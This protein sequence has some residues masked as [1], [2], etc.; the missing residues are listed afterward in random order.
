M[1]LKIVLKCTYVENATGH[2]GRNWVTICSHHENELP[3]IRQFEQGSFNLKLRDPQSYEPPKE[4][5][6]KAEAR[7]RG[8]HDGNHISQL[9]KVVELNGK[10]VEARFYRGGHPNN[11]IELLSKV[12]LKELL[13]IRHGAEVI[14]VVVENEEMVQLALRP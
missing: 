14:V 6:Y 8:Q 11:T 12:R 7:L 9:A 10:A 2:V 1:P 4:R 3:E 13:D 5:E